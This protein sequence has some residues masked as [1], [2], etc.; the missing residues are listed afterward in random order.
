[1][2][3]DKSWIAKPRN[4]TEYL[5]GL[6][7]FLDFAF[8]NGSVGDA[9]KCP[10]PKCGFVKWQKRY[11]VR[12]HLI[13]KSF[14]RTYEIWTFHGEKIIQ[15]P[16]TS[17][18]VMQEVVEPSNPIEM[19]INEAFGLSKQHATEF[20]TSQQP[21]DTDAVLMMNLIKILKTS[22]SYS[23]MEMKNYIKVARNTR[24]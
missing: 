17:T 8:A 24:S 10:C 2:S 11:V 4:T 18:N 6:D 3:I 20:N 13:C 12:D 21:I 5:D 9:I 7:K 1:M 22:M 23:E 14:P 19:M 16:C 15:Q